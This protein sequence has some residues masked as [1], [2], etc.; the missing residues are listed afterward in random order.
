LFFWLTQTGGVTMPIP[1]PLM[2]GHLINYKSVDKVAW[3]NYFQILNTVFISRLL[4][5]RLIT[6]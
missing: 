5:L 3:E 1:E 6:F 4:N 2:G